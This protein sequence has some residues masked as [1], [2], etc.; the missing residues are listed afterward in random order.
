VSVTIARDGHVIEAHIID[1]SGDSGLDRS[2]QD[3]LDRV[4]EI[5]PFP[6]DSND[7]QRTYIINFNLKAKRELG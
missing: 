7:K 6:D 2:I 5:R 3:T 4:T 1:K